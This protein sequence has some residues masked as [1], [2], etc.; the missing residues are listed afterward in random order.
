MENSGAGCVNEYMGNLCG[1]LS[2]RFQQSMCLGVHER[3]EIQPRETAGGD[4]EQIDVFDGEAGGSVIDYLHSVGD[5][6]DL[7]HTEGEPDLVWIFGGDGEWHLCAE[8]V[9]CCAL[10]IYPGSAHNC[11]EG[12]IFDGPVVAL[13]ALFASATSFEV[14]GGRLVC[15]EVLEPSD[16]G[17]E[18]SMAAEGEAPNLEYSRD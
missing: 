8:C 15:E 1:G 16:S 11:P 3:S 13:P 7:P 18:S 2:R 17:E 14:E 9:H 5:Y 12:D 4:P 6:D 10:M